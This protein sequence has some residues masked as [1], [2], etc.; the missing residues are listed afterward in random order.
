MKQIKLDNCQVFSSTI[1]S[2]S[3]NNPRV[4]ALIGFYNISS[5]KKLF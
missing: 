2:S 3:A 1:T 4:G 5:T